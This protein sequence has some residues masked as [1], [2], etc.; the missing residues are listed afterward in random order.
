MLPVILRDVVYDVSPW[1]GLPNW[2]QRKNQIKA[3][4]KNLDET[5]TYLARYCSQKRETGVASRG[6]A[7]VDSLLDEC[8]M[9][10]HWLLGFSWTMELRRVP[11]HKC[12]W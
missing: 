7:R 12:S 9:V 1:D 8:L 2:Y 6:R 5:P 4:L 11:R 3:N 10:E